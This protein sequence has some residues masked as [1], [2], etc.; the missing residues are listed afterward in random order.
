MRCGP[1]PDLFGLIAATSNC[2]AAAGACAAT[3]DE[4]EP[5][6]IMMVTSAATKTTTFRMMLLDVRSLTLASWSLIFKV[7][8]FHSGCP[9]GFASI[10][11]RYML[12]ERAIR[13]S[14]R[15]AGRFSLIR[16]AFVELVDDKHLARPRCRSQL[17]PQLFL[18]GCDRARCV[19]GRRDI[20]RRRAC[21]RC[22]LRRTQR[23]HGR[24][25]D[26]VLE[27]QIEVAGNSGP[28]HHNPL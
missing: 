7:H 24:L 25:V 16:S 28:V 12:L 4:V 20:R 22:L 1:G 14:F 10:I 3:H 19:G 17:Q 13:S 5:P 27:I 11:S 23:S 15:S 26:G 2:G 21:D 18:Q 8:L 9:A 6:T